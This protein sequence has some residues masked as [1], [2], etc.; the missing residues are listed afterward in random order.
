MTHALALPKTKSV[1]PALIAWPA[2]LLI[3]LLPDILLKELTG[4]LLPWLFWVKN[5][6]LA[7]AILVGLAWKPLGSLRLFFSVVLALHLLEWGTDRLLNA[8]HYQSWLAGAAPFIQDVGSVQIARVLSAVGMVLVMLVLLGSPKRFFLVKG[9]LNARA[10]PIPLLLTRPPVWHLLGPAIAGAMCLGLI[11]FIFILGHPPTMSG[12][13]QVLP[14]LPFVLLFA[15][16]NAFGEEMLYRAPWLAALETP[17]GPAHALLLTA[18]YFGFG[19]FYGV[20][21]GILGCVMAFI[22]G[23]LMG[24]AMLET[25]GFLWPWI[26]H[27]CMDAVIFFALALGSVAPGG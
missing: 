17:I 9:D 7:A 8:L 6:L 2:M 25:R 22:P 16:A 11:V 5:A 27:F 23:W 20:P 13:S 10:G 12:I 21:Y 14:L 3:S 26:I 1:P 18:V 24:K 4:S 15:A 19:H